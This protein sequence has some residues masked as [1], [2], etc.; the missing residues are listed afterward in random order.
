RRWGPRRPRGCA[1]GARPRPPRGRHLP[2]EATLRAHLLQGHLKVGIGRGAMTPMHI[3]VLDE[4]TAAAAALYDTARER[5]NGLAASVE[6]VMLPDR[7]V[8]SGPR[9]HPSGIREYRGTPEE[10]ARHV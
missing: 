1:G 6:R 10:A 8:I 4:G 2:G 7:H 5:L 3:V 9:A